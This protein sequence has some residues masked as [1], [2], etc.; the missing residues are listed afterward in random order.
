MKLLERS[1]LLSG[2]KPEES[3]TDGQG[4]A[5]IASSIA[6]FPFRHDY[7]SKAVRLS[8]HAGGIRALG[9]KKTKVALT[10]Y[11]L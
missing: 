10:S 8:S 11:L 4:L 1:T 5:W 7:A 3:F 6:V 2:A 9:G